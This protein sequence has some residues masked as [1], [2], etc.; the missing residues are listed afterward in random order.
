MRRWQRRR[1]SARVARSENTKELDELDGG[2]S[3]GAAS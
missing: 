3:L 2:D 1:L